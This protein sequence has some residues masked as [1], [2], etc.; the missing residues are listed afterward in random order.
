M[1]DGIPNIGRSLCCAGRRD[2]GADGGLNLRDSG[3]DRKVHFP[4]LEEKRQT[5]GAVCLSLGV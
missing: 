5:A 3:A 4:H 1:Q 2:D